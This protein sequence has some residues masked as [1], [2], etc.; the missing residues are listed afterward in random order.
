[1]IIAF[2]WAPIALSE[3]P[4]PTPPKGIQQEQPKATEGQRR[5][6]DSLPGTDTKPL[7]VDIH[8]APATQPKTAEEKQDEDYKTFLEQ[9]VGWGTVALAGITL[10]LA[11]A[12]YGLYRVT[13]QLSKDAQE[14]GKTQAK[15]VAQSIAE[16]ARAAAAMEGLTR[17]S[18][19]SAEFS[20]Q[21]VQLSLNEFTASHRPRLK[22]HS[23]QI[24]RPESKEASNI[25]IPNTFISGKFSINNF[26]DTTATVITGSADFFKATRKTLPMHGVFSQRRFSWQNRVGIGAGTTVEFP[27][28]SRTQ[29]SEREISN[30]LT[31]GN[32]VLFFVGWLAY[33]DEGNTPVARK[34]AFC[35]RY[36]HL[37]ERFVTV[38]DPDYEHGE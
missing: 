1:V 17:Q 21:A 31:G 14:T 4:S 5:P 33:L 26:G 24:S 16:A 37:S 3:P 29:L 6:D 34:I 9:L 19:I 8:R 20:Q 2:G 18:A 11:V 12:T 38:D 13:V 15:Q 22:V 36:D 28:I 35:R 32:C 7:V 30:I 10:G 25:F 23:I 27:F